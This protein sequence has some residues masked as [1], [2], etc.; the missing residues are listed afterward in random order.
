MFVRANRKG[1]TSMQFIQ[2]QRVLALWRDIVRSTANIPDEAA[3]KD[4]RQFA[5]SEFE[6]HR[7][8]TDLHGKTQ[9]QAMK[10]TLINSGILTE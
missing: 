2:R 10:D 9:F 8:V 1:L 4:M 7:R 6:Q 3:R 5:R